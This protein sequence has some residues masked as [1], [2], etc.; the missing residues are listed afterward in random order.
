MSQEMEITTPLPGTP[1]KEDLEEI[2]RFA[3]RELK[4]E[5]VF[6]FPVILCDNEVDRDF[7]CFT[8][9]SLEML[10]QLF[11]GKTGIFDHDPKGE[12]QTARIYKTQVTADPQRLT[13]QGQPYTCLKAH[14]YMVRAEKNRDLILE[15]EGGIKKEVSVGCTVEKITCSICGSDQREAPCDH[16]KGETYSLGG[17]ERK[18]C[19]HLLENPT[20]AYEWSFVAVPAQVEAGIT[21]V[22]RTEGTPAGSLCGSLLLAKG[23]FTVQG[24]RLE[25]LKEEVELLREQARLGS[26]AW[27]QLQEETARLNGLA[28]PEMAGE[29][30]R[31]M[32]K[33]LSQEELGRLRQAL[34]K[35]LASQYPC[36]PQT[37]VPDQGNAQEKN[38][39]EFR[40]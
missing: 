3:H 31:Q 40:I 29:L 25:K 20:D 33:G 17:R 5:E 6:V 13:S 37:W 14:A 30:S 23:S 28:H 36:F 4:A 10:A 16:R 11:V 27:R 9:P 39:G 24:A 32:V 19:Y 15:I 35:Q 12:N 34:E 21:K 8:V 1:T 7:E 22:K 18:L 2:N 38:W 26:Q